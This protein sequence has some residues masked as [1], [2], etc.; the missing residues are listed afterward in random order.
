MTTGR[1]ACSALT[2]E[3]G[4]W[5]FLLLICKTQVR[6]RRVGDQAVRFL[7]GGGFSGESRNT[8]SSFEGCASEFFLEACIHR[9]CIQGDTHT[10][11]HTQCFLPTDVSLETFR[12][13]DQSTP[14]ASKSRPALAL[15]SFLQTRAC[16]HTAHSGSCSL[17]IHSCGGLQA[18]PG[19]ASFF[20]PLS[21]SLRDSSTTSPQL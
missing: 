16:T 18:W 20:S 7:M 5:S 15:L 2:T 4:L 19:T 1:A 8:K 3:E 14:R 9:Y 10:H 11:T 12:Y 13:K 21:P 17:F 6:S